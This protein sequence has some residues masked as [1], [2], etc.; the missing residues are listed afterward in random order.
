[1]R[2]VVIT[3]L[4]AVTPIG[5]DAPST[6]DA[7]VSG[8]SGVGW[9]EAFDASEY[10]VRIAAEASGF[11]IGDLVPAVDERRL[12][13]CLQDFYHDFNEQVLDCPV[14]AFLDLKNPE[15][16]ARSLLVHDKARK[17]D[18]VER[19]ANYAEH[20]TAISCRQCGPIGDVV[21]A[22]EQ[23]ED[24]RLVHIDTAFDVLCPMLGREHVRLMSLRAAEKATG[25]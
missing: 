16:R 21:I 3:G 9:I 1:M 15:S 11:Q 8:R 24:C 6:W 14:N 23:P 18:S 20:G 25:E 13:N 17:L 5:L 10:P 12:L 4:G 2:R 22:L 19:L 7:A